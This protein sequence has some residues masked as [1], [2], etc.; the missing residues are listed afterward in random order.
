MAW[1]TRGRIIILMLNESANQQWNAPGKRYGFAKRALF[2]M[3]RRFF[4]VMH[5]LEETVLV[6]I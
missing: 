3:K 5:N 6:I 1:S 2:Q 4:S